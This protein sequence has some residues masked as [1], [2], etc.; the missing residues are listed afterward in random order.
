MTND[1]RA[2]WDAAWRSM[3]HHTAPFWNEDALKGIVGERALPI[4]ALTVSQDPPQFAERMFRATT[5]CPICGAETDEVARVPVSL[6][7][8]FD[9]GPPR[10]KRS[11]VAHGAWV[12][13]R[14][15]GE[16]PLTDEPTPIP[17]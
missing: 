17:W 15:L 3:P 16:C 5:I 9:F 4:I 2:E 10:G 7:P 13:S 11:P 6:H 1:D 8:V 12:H 14:C